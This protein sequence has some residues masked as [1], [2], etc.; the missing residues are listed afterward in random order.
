MSG[1]YI[2]NPHITKKRARQLVDDL[3]SEGHVVNLNKMTVRAIFDPLFI[4]G[5]SGLST[6]DMVF[7]SKEISKATSNLNRISHAKGKHMAFWRREYS[8]QIKVMIEVFCFLKHKLKA[9]S[10]KKLVECRLSEECG[11]PEELWL[12]GNIEVTIHLESDGS[13][14]IIVDAGDWEHDFTVQCSSMSVL[15]NQ[16]AAYVDALPEE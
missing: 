6:D 13:G 10:V 12:M 3:C 7:V 4:V 1:H 2:K 16:A 8:R 14:H 9:H 11:C 15:R 5:A